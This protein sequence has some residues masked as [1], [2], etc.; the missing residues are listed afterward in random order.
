VGL[1]HLRPGGRLHLRQA[2]AIAIGAVGCSGSGSASRAATPA[3]TSSPTTSRPTGTTGVTAVHDAAATEIA[4]RPTV[5]GGGNTSETASVQA[6]GAGGTTT[7]GRLPV[8]R[9]DLAAASVAGRAYLV[10]GYDGA[11]VT[12]RQRVDP[13]RVRTHILPACPTSRCRRWS[14]SRS[15]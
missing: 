9:S 8:P 11:R 3:S 1:V 12:G 2:I 14:T 7:I 10:G 13:P 5:F 6:V 15:G 4:G